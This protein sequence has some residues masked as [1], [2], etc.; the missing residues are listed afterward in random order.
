MTKLQLLLGGALLLIWP[1]AV[2]AQAIPVVYVCTPEGQVLEVNGTTA[3]VLAPR[4]GAFDDCVL[5]PDGWLYISEVV[6][7]DPA[8]NRIVRLDPDSTA[9]QLGLVATLPNAAAPRGLAFNITAANVAP[10]NRATLFINT[11]SSGVYTLQETG[12]TAIPLTFPTA[13]TQIPNSPTTSGHGLTFGVLGDLYVATDSTIQRAA[14][15][16]TTFS[17]LVSNASPQDVTVN[18]CREIVYT[19][20]A[21]QSL[22]RIVNNSTKTLLKLS[23]KAFPTAAEADLGNHIYFLS[24]EDDAGTNAILWRID[25]PANA[26]LA[27]SCDTA[28]ATPLIDFKAS[29]SGGSLIP[30]LLS[31]RARG[32]AVGLSSAMISHKFT[33]ECRFA[34]DFGHHVVTYTFDPPCAAASGITLEV[35]TYKSKWADVRFTTPPFGA[36]PTTWGLRE[37]SM[38]AFAVQFVLHA[39]KDNLDL[40]TLPHYIQTYAFNTQEK[41][42]APGLARREEKDLTL[43]FD[44]N[45]TSDVWNVDPIIGVRGI[46]GSKHTLFNSSLAKA[47]VLDSKFQEPLNSNNPL[48]NGPQTLFIG[49][50]ATD[51]TGKPC[52][53]GTLHVSLLRCADVGCQDGPFEPQLVTSS[54]QS[55]NV[56]SPLGKGK[57]GYNLDLTVVN[58][59]G[60]EVSSVQF[61]ITVW[62]D[63]AEPKNQLF[64][65]SKSSK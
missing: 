8:P 19:D 17:T 64:L 20:K 14:P 27:A 36:P 23:K 18:T 3:R 7:G 62:S 55:G 29:L 37:S 44:E 51:A 42:F 65:V 13:A 5:G 46:S 61:V 50:G 4:G 38:G 32:L 59:S 31:S 21:S 60:A 34:Y 11:A 47:C 16:Y 45:I 57:Y 22:K 30:G 9:P 49:I 39:S 41:M 43:P 6:A 35:A 24:A 12:A 10:F 26:P 48:F 54:V 52:D 15:F 2:L 53:G 33:G 1:S 28:I 25:P 40:S 58:T 56:M 63:I